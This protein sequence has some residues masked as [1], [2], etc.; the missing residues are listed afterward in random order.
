MTG[1]ALHP[2]GALLAPLVMV[3]TPIHVW[4]LAIRYVGD[5]RA[6]VVP[7][8]PVAVGVRQ[9]ARC[10]G[11]SA[12]ALCGLAASLPLVL[13]LPTWAA[14]STLALRLPILGVSVGVMLRPSASR[15]WALFKLS[16]PYLGLL[17]LVVAVAG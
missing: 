3:W 12:L 9:A 10:V 15:A 14:V 5:Y 11:W 4:S 2:V 16:S 7:M 6:A 13:D 1:T 17:F 8:P